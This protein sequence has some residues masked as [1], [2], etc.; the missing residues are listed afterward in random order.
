MK[1]IDKKDLKAKD[2]STKELHTK[3]FTL[4]ELLCLAAIIIAL[5]TVHRLIP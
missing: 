4:V 3:D 5:A 1:A 2:L